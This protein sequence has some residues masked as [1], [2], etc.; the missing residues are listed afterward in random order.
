[1]DE[2]LVLR[3]GPMQVELVEAIYSKL[4]EY[5]SRQGFS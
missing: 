1:M 4:M 5:S 3:H 2:V